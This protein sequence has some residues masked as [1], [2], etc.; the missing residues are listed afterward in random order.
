M[1]KNFVKAQFENFKEKIKKYFSLKSS[2]E[3][4]MSLSTGIHMIPMNIDEIINGNRN[5]IGFRMTIV[6][7]IYSLFLALNC[8]LF[9][10]SSYLFSLLKFKSMPDQ[11]KL[12]ILTIAFV[13]LLMVTIRIDLILDEIKSKLSSLKIFY[14]LINNLQSKHKLTS[15]N[16]NRLAILSKMFKL[17]VLDVGTSTAIILCLAFYYFIA[18]SIQ[19]SVWILQTILY[20]PALI[21]GIT[22][23]CWMCIFFVI[24][25]YYKFRFDQINHQIKSLI[26]NGKIIGNR[27]QKHLIKL[28]NQHNLAS[29]EIH[30]INLMIRRTTAVKFIVFSIAKVNIVYL[31]INF[32]NVLIKMLAFDA[33]MT[34]VLFSFLLNYLFT[35]QIK[36]AH[37]SYKLIYSIICTHK[38]SF[39][40]KLKVNQNIC[41][42]LFS[43]K[44]FT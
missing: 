12:I 38:M 40:F 1:I 16:L 24:F 7:L 23:S 34:L 6:N 9:S 19:N 17:I 25:L 41:F 39:R 33:I 31:L 4:L 44:L 15:A 8:F 21:N 22:I 30:K 29:I 13:S 20:T 27:R 10:T 28:I 11:M 14:Y 32:N 42:N 5:E 26:R 43:H 35:Q 37:K 2:I 36:S 18:I 3:H